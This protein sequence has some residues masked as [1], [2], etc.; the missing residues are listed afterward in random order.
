MENVVLNPMIGKNSMTRLSQETRLLAG[1]YLTGKYQHRIKDAGFRLADLNLPKDCP[2]EI[3]HGKNT[4]LTAEKI[5]FGY[6]ARGTSGG[7][8]FEYSGDRP[9]D[10]WISGS[11]NVHQSY[12]CRFR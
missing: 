11:E 7:K 8:R 6:S 1:R 4:I 3:R 10:P 5:Q 12:H 2:P 9:Q